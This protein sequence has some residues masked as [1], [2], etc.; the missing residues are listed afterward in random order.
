MTYRVAIIEEGYLDQPKGFP[1]EDARALWM[2]GFH[3]GVEYS[4]LGS[5]YAVATRSS[6]RYSSIS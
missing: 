6:R 1:S 4:G 2:E 3:D 5:T